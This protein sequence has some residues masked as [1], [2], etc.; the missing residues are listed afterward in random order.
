MAWNQEFGSA[1]FKVRY[2]SR[3]D[4]LIKELRGIVIAF[5]SAEDGPLLF[6][7]WSDIEYAIYVEFGTYKMAPRAMIRS[8]MDEV[9]DYCAKQY[10]TE[11]A[12]RIVDGTL[13]EKAFFAFRAG[14]IQFA[15]DRIRNK[16]P[17]RTAE[18]R[19]ADGDNPDAPHLQ[20]E[21]YI[22]A[23]SDHAEY[24]REF[25]AEVSDSGLKF[26]GRLNRKKAQHPEDQNYHK[27]AHHYENNY[28]P[29]NS[30]PRR[31]GRKN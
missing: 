23:D 9:R 27:Q 12:N 6:R 16:T 30:R 2:T 7:I 31:Y 25:T 5:K 28:D 29:D 4:E 19:I 15:L 21:I 1:G 13:T 11:I 14:V 8:S 20:D 22:G 17:R 10:Q 3:I 24:S 26:A 18:Q